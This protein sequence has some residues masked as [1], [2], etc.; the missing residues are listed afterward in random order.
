[1]RWVQSRQKDARFGPPLTG[2]GRFL[3]LLFAGRADQMERWQH[4]MDLGAN[5]NSLQAA[6]A[7]ID[8]PV[9]VLIDELMDYVMA[10]TDASA[11]G[12]AGRKGVP[13]RADG[14]GR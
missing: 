9:P 14:R 7:E 6:F 12:D 4:Y 3:W 1:M 2:Y 11:I 5:K 10:L 8:R 13:Q